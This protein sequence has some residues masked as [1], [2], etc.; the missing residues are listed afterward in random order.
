MHRYNIK[1]YVIRPLSKVYTVD[2]LFMPLYSRGNHSLFVIGLSRNSTRDNGHAKRERIRLL[3]DVLDGH[4]AC[5]TR[6]CVSLLRRRNFSP[7]PDGRH[8]EDGLLL[9]LVCTR[10]QVQ[11]VLLITKL[12][13][14]VTSMYAHTHARILSLL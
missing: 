7:D 11:Q 13:N 10:I 12:G 3:R 4:P 14:I 5:A 8:A 1:S 6:V 2:L 9:V